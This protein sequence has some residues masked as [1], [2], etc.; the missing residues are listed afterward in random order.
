MTDLAW[1]TERPIAHRGYHDMNGAIWEN[2]LPAFAR[3]A[4]HGYTIECDV[5]LSSDGIPVV[6]HDDTLSRLTGTEGY[7]WQRTAAEMGA[8]RIGGTADH[9]PRLTEILEFVAGRVPLVIELK[10]CP[11]KDEGL[12]TEVARALQNYR[13]KAAIMSF[14]HWLIRDFGRHAPGIPAGL[15]AWGEKDH[16]L[17]AH[18]SM[19]AHGIDFVSYSVVHLPNRFVSFVRER[20][21]MP[22]ISWTVRDQPAVEKTFA[23]VDQMT[24][25]GFQPGTVA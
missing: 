20:L 19:L 11:G 13:G 6:F 3:A 7:V 25:E 10:G 9:A 14:D 5:R 24:F 23:N 22:V 16:E 12:V 21:N 8:L 4:E 18:F 17:E 2:T 15:T 1:L